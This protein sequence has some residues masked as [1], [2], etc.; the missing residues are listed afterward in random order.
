[1]LPPPPGILS[2]P[3]PLGR[4]QKVS[5]EH[6]SQHSQSS[7]WHKPPGRPPVPLGCIPPTSAQRYQ[8]SSYPVLS[9][10]SLPAS[11]TGSHVLSFLFWDISFPYL[12][13]PQTSSALPLQ[14]PHLSGE[15]KSTHC[16]SSSGNSISRCDRKHMWQVFYLSE[17]IHHSSIITTSCQDKAKFPFSLRFKWKSLSIFWLAS[18]PVPKDKCYRIFSVLNS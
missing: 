15:Q 5:W 12:T 8:L 17:L 7:T 14:P 18:I 11:S 2:W 4:Q 3:L 6:C 13:H 1:M 16:N 9:S 10:A